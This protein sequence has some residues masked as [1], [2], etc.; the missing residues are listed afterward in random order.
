MILE[1]WV[2]VGVVDEIK[3]ITAHLGWSWLAWAELGKIHE[4]SKLWC[5]SGSK[6][7]LIIIFL[8]GILIYKVVGKSYC[9]LK[10]FR[11]GSG[12]VRSGRLGCR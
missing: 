10:L 9:L 8:Y 1:G 7:T 4:R 12:W 2:G 3:A 5:V 6:E 11:V